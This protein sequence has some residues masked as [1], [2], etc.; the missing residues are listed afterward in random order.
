MV[1]K[2]NLLSL[3]SY[4]FTYK[5]GPISTQP[6]LA[7]FCFPDILREKI[8]TAS[9]SLYSKG[10][11]QTTFRFWEDSDNPK[12]TFC[13]QL[14]QDIHKEH[15]MQVYLQCATSCASAYQ[16]SK[17]VIITCNILKVQKKELKIS[18]YRTTLEDDKIGSYQLHL[19]GTEIFF[20][21]QVCIRNKFHL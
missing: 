18:I 5:R 16:D 21:S 11:P 15:Y 12:W 1:L 17:N 19:V 7:N 20:L 6:K 8:S 4:F 13:S 2:I 3:L 9:Q 10:Y 14:F